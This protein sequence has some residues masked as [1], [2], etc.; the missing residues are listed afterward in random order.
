MLELLY[1]DECPV[2]FPLLIFTTEHADECRGVTM[3]DEIGLNRGEYDGI[4]GNM[5]KFEEI[6]LKER[7]SPQ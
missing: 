2:L 7:N 5:K 4:G 1:D 6:G 3:R